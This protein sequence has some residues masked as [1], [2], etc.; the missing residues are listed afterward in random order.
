M[1]VLFNSGVLILGLLAVVVKSDNRVFTKEELAKYNGEDV[2]SLIKM[3]H[4]KLIK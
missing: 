4:L 1:K 2:R 3:I